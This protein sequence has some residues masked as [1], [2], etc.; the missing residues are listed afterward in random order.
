MEELLPHKRKTLRAWLCLAMH[1]HELACS[2]KIQNGDRSTSAAFELLA[3]VCL[4][5][6]LV[7]NIA[8]VDIDLLFGDLI[9]KVADNH[10]H[11]GSDVGVVPAKRR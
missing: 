4:D 9:G 8:K 6:E 3:V 2:T 5:A 1:H 11:L 10:L 7:E